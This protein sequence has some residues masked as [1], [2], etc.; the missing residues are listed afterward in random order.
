MFLSDKRHMVTMLQKTEKKPDP[1]PQVYDVDLMN[2]EQE[3][4]PLDVPIPTRVRFVQQDDI[5]LTPKASQ[6]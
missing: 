4:D 6:S 1:Q 2:A 5:A 3:E